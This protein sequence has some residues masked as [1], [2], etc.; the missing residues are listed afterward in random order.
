MLQRVPDKMQHD[1]V[2]EMRSA[3]LKQAKEKSSASAKFGSDY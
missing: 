1:P 2:I 3:I